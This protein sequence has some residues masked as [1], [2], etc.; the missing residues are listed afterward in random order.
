[1]YWN[2]Q[3]V[4]Q[5]AVRAAGREITVSICRDQCTD[6]VEQQLTLIVEPLAVATPET[7]QLGL[8]FVALEVW[9]STAF[10]PEKRS[11]LSA[12]SPRR[13]L[14]NLL[15]RRS[16]QLPD[17]ALQGI[18]SLS[19]THSAGQQRGLSPNSRAAQAAPGATVSPHASNSAQSPAKMVL[20]ETA[21]VCPNEINSR[22]GTGVLLQYMF[23]RLDKMAVLE[24]TRFYNRDR[25]PTAVTWEL[26]PALPRPEVYRCVLDWFGHSAPRRAYVVPYLR[27]DLLM[28]LALKDLFG[29]R[30]VLH[31]MDDNT[32]IGH[33]I[34]RDLME[35]VIV[36]SDVR[37]AISP[38]MRLA[39]E[40]RYGHKFYLLPPVVRDD[41]IGIP[42]DEAAMP[43]ERGAIIGNLWSPEWVERLA[44]TVRQSG[45]QLDWFC[46][47]PS[48][49]WVANKRESLAD[50]GVCLR[51]PLWGDD[52]VKELRRRPFLLLP[53]GEPEDRSARAI[54]KLSL[55]SRAVFHTAAVQTPI[56]VLGNEE[57]AVAGFVKQFQLG[58]VVPYQSA[59]LRESATRLSQPNEA[60][61]VRAACQAIAPHF[62]A[63]DLE[64]WIWDSMLEGRPADDRFE[65]LF[66]AQPGLANYIAP[67]PPRG[68]SW[69]QHTAWQMLVRYQLRGGAP[70]TILDVGAACGRWSQMASQIFP[71][72]HLVLFEPLLQRYPPNDRE[73]G[74]QQLASYETIEQVVT[75]HCGH[76][77]LTVSE[78]LYG[79]SLL[80]VDNM[81]GPASAAAVECTTLDAASQSRGW[82]GPMLLHADV[83]HAEHL[84]ITGA[85]EL[86]RSQIDAVLL[87]LCLDRSHPQAKTYAEM[88]EQM[89]DF[90]FQLFDETDGWRDPG[91][92]QLHMKQVLFVKHGAH[93]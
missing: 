17:W 39:Y 88:V 59:A 33:G 38:E 56:L 91:S 63:R 18:R 32:L 47:N 85:A 50:D 81:H 42:H 67:N 80:S 31:V 25:V 93:G 43:C 19:H 57:T 46:N 30:L 24:S 26:P 4:P 62:S 11:P 65:S 64:Q 22:H 41:L 73:W 5:S 20:C 86:L 10:V 68:L 3:H 13:R 37:F 23:P 70:R 48:T 89:R 52:L 82:S 45:L 78:N 69:S 58:A 8:P 90:K 9:P 27:S 53:T 40:Q 87:N 66:S 15:R 54:A 71:Q 28:A 84:V 34:P 60:Q 74:L 79:S 72:A 51:D 92:G 16:P 76:S 14:R 61:C 75:D 83:Q 2:D 12:F 44:D 49:P 77:N 35:E 29:T 7:R 1:V 21:I 6:E 36:K 55:P